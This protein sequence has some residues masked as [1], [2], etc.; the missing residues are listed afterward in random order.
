MREKVKKREREREEI[1]IDSSLCVRID[2][3][4]FY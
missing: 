2:E 3:K 1:Y 4:Y